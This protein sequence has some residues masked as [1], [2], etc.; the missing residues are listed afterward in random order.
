[1]IDTSLHATRNRRVVTSAVEYPRDFPKLGEYVISVG[2]FLVQHYNIT[3]FY[4]VAAMGNWKSVVAEHFQLLGMKDLDAVRISY[5]GDL[6]G[7]D[8]VLNT[9]AEAGVNAAIVRQD[10]DLGAF[11]RPAMRAI[12]AWVRTR[13]DSGSILYFHT[14]GVS[15]PHDPVKRQ[16]RQLMNHEVLANWQTTVQELDWFDVVGVNW[17]NCRPNAHF[18]GNFWWAR[19]EWLRM[20]TPFDTYCDSRAGP[21]Y[22]DI[23]RRLACEFWISSASRL[24]RVRSLVCADQDFVDPSFWPGLFHPALG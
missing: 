1:M 9:A 5:V 3:A 2:R 8:Y 23:G 7:I 17:R 24:P 11:E 19:S 22:N 14:K 18:C 21:M 16:W 4:H 12:E 20:L 13:P 6:D 15:A 10:P